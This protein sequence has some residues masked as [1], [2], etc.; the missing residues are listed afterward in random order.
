[1]SVF[2]AAVFLYSDVQ[3]PDAHSVYYIV[4]EGSL[5]V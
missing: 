3:E 1:M 4:K 5:C 2:P